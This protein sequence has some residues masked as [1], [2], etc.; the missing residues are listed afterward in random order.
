MALCSTVLALEPAT[1][2][3]L[4]SDLKANAWGLPGY[5]A[6]EVLTPPPST[7]ESVAEGKR[8]SQ[9]Y[10]ISCHGM[11]LN[12]EGYDESI[13]MTPAESL[14]YTPNYHFGDLNLSIFR[15]IKYGFPKFSHTFE[16]SMTD[17]QIWAL[18]SYVRSLQRK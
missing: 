4:L 16:E 1:R 11:S 10:C 5:A 14:Q 6:V 8:L 2:S 3:E 7:P 18:T 12:G 13:N 9:T 17:E 15:S